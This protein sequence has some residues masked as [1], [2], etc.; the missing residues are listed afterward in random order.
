MVGINHPNWQSRKLKGKLKMVA[1]PHKKSCL[2]TACQ[3]MSIDDLQKLEQKNKEKYGWVFHVVV[4]HPI[5]GTEV[6]THGLL[7]K[8]GHPDLQLCFDFL[9][10]FPPD[11]GKQVIS[12][13]LWDFV[14]RIK[15]GETF[16]AEQRVS[17]ILKG[18]DVRLVAATENQ[19]PVLRII[20]PDKD[21]N[22]DLM[23]LEG[24][25]ADQFKGLP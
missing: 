11:R 9:K 17:G 19:R 5:Y 8:Y 14:N 22:L 15:D 4:E 20:I 23:M 1:F 18:Y 2:C 21:G 6:H 25:F 7:E 24:Y 3:G 10:C 13:I 16:S 12:N